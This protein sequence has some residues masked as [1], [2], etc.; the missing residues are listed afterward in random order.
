MLNRCFL[1]LLLCVVFTAVKS[2]TVKKSKADSSKTI[3][4]KQYTEPAFKYHI[5]PPAKWA[6]YDTVLNGLRIRILKAPKSLGS[7][8]PI[9][10]VLI[11][12]M[13]G[14][15]INDFTAS[16]ITY[17]KTTMAGISILKK[18]TID[19]VYNGQ[20]FTYTKMQN[21]VLRE[22]INYIIPVNGLAYMITCGTNKGT[23]I[24]YR[25]V[26]DKIARS[27]KP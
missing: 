12:N 15:N 9:V 24:K 26:F 6:M 4:A 18:G 27:F 20:W 14:K 23:I 1:L 17:L 22:M 3:K 5:T 10:N 2:Q 13:E 8:N 21:G 11:A 19:T 7:D 16:N 25:P